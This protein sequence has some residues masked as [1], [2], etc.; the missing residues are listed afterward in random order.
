MFFFFEH[1]IIQE[2]KCIFEKCTLKQQRFSVGLDPN[3]VSIPGSDPK[4]LQNCT[5]RMVREELRAVFRS[6][7]DPVFQDGSG[8]FKNRILIRI[9]LE[10]RVGSDSGQS[11][12][13]FEPPILRSSTQGIM[14]NLLHTILQWKGRTRFAIIRQLFSLNLL[15]FDECKNSQ[16]TLNQ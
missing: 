9:F 7:P 4:S 14:F 3:Q 6:D 13:G 1:T 8:F 2:K 11:Q 5:Y 10:A 12:L 15:L 16:F